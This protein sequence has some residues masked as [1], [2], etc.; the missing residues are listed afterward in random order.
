MGKK[1]VLDASAGMEQ[2]VFLPLFTGIR[3][4]G[5]SLELQE[6]ENISYM[7]VRQDSLYALM[8]RQMEKKLSHEVVMVY[9]ERLAGITDS[10]TETSLRE[11]KTAY[12]T[13]L[14][15]YKK[16]EVDLLKTG[17][18]LECLRSK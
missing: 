8:K 14:V 11:A 1:Y 3:I 15:R 9:Q 18:M 12:T 16:A 2:V 4:A 7:T 10:E 6:L 13:E 5:N 17:G